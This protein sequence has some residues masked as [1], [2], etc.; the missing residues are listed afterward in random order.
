M[1]NIAINNYC[2][3]KCDYC[4]ANDM[5]KEV[6]KTMSLENYIKILKYLTEQNCEEHIGI[7]GGEP[8][9]HPQF[10]DILIETNQC[11]NAN[12]INF[13][14]FTN[15]IELEPYLSYIGSNINILINCNDFM[16][17]SFEQVNK[18]RSTLHH[19]F[20]LGWIHNEKVICGC[21]LHLN[22]INYN[23]IW[24]LV[25]A[26]H[27]PRLRCSVVSPGGCYTLWRQNKDEYFNRMKPIFLNFCREA[28]RRKVVINI[29]CGYIPSCYFSKE[30]IE[31]IKEVTQLKYYHSDNGCNP[32][33]D[34]TPDLQVTPCFGAYKLF[35][36]D[37]SKNWYGF[38]KY[39]NYNNN[40][41]KALNNKQGPCATCEKLQNFQCQGGCLAFSSPE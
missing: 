18:F 38:I 34:I 6:N 5:I 35:P 37:F 27:I 39:I 8:T 26:Y 19:I 41:P 32:V 21:N 29:D 16:K 23:W 20:Q 24:E 7:I 11:A 40:M 33:M 28:Q 9:I 13:T 31:L 1:A 17:M 4:F 15:G 22:E 3:L 2:N 30:E 12:K 10:K 36:L 14:L 25:D